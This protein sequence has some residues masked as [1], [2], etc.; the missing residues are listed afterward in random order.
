MALLGRRLRILCAFA[1][2]GTG[3]LA[4]GQSPAPEYDLKAA[5]LLNFARFVEWPDL[6]PGAPVAICVLGK[7]PFGKALDEVVEN[8]SAGGRRIVVRRISSAAQLG[9]CQVVFIAS[10]EKHLAEILAAAEKARALT[11]GES[12]AFLEEGGIIRLLAGDKRVAFEINLE[13]ASRAGL[14][15]SSQLLR[16]ARVTKNSREGPK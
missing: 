13:V 7:D 4:A 9:N 1:L 15:I 11:V 12:E 2:A 8:R 3:W 14:T 6:A 10:Q 16:V 5:F